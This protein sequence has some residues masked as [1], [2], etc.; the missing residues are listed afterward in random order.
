MEGVHVDVTPPPV[1]QFAA[2]PPDPSVLDEVQF[3]DQSSDPGGAGI[4]GWSWAFGDGAS[5]TGRDVQHRYAADGDYTVSHTVTT[6]DGRTATGTLVVRVRTHDVQISKLT[7]PR[8]ASV[9]QTHWI[10]VSV[11]D[12]HYPETVQ[13][14]LLRSTPSGWARVGTLTQSIPAGKAG[15][16]TEFAFSYTFTADDANGGNVSFRAV[17]AIQGA[18]DAH[19]SDNDVTALPTRVR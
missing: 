12:T 2:M 11:S 16:R 1:T 14:Q 18:R 13:V 15:R 8:S 9:G 3:I 10:S 4:S 5:A 6:T 7:V 19:P 17:A